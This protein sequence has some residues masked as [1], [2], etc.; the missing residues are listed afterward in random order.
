MR[1]TFSSIIKI[2]TTGLFLSLG[3][4]I[5]EGLSLAEPAQ[6]R[7]SRCTV[8]I[9]EGVEI[10]ANFESLSISGLSLTACEDAARSQ[11]EVLRSVR[12]AGY[13]SWRWREGRETKRGQFE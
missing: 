1:A 2:L 3:F 9:V 13:V 8:Q 6:K 11:F 10:G 12:S 5:S 4:A 7:P